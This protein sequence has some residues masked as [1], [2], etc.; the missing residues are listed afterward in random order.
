MGL[1]LVPS[2]HGYALYDRIIK[3]FVENFRMAAYDKSISSFSIDNLFTYT[4]GAFEC[5]PKQNFIP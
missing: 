5:I 4:C 3:K 1:V 2:L